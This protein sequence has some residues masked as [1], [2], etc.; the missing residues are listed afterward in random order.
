MRK[1]VLKS[2]IWV[3]VCF[4]SSNGWSQTTERDREGFSVIVNTD[5]EPLSSGPFSPHWE[6]LQQYQVPEWF[7]DAKFGIWA[8]WGPQCEP[9][10]GDW[11]ARLM[12]FQGLP[13]YD[14]HLKQYGH[15]SEVGFKEVIHA[16]EGE[17][18]NPDQL[19][20]LF[21]KAGAKYFFAMANHHDNLDLWDSRYHAW[22]S[23]KV[24]P[25]KNIV[26]GW[27]RAS[28]KYKLPF[29]LSVHSSHAWTWYEGTLGSDKTG[30]RGGVAYDGHLRKEDGKGTWWEGLDP[31]ELYA[32]DHPHSTD[33]DVYSGLFSQ[34][35][36]ENGASLPDQAYCDNF[37]NR[38]MDLIRRYRPDLVYFDDTV[39]PLY[40]FSDA[41]LKI[42][43][44]FYNENLSLNRGKQ[45]GVVFG[46]MLSEAQRKAMVWDIERGVSHEILP[47]P[48][49]TCTCIGQW[50]YDRSVYE[51][52]EYKSALTVLQMLSDIV[53]K[54]GNLLLSVPIRGDGSLDE[55]E[56]QILEDIAGWIK[57]NGEAIF[58][59]RPWKIFGESPSRELLGL[60]EQG[61][62]ENKENNYSHRDIRFTTRGDI[63][64]A[65]ILQCD[66][67]HSVEIASLGKNSSLISGRKIQKI[68]Q[69]GSTG[70]PDWNQENNKLTVRIDGEGVVVLRIEGLL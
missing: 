60:K 16:W 19:V 43:S 46:K 48:W 32:N 59:T 11:Y 24:G 55:K 68:K 51:K 62:D 58:E 65:I 61:F 30:P 1:V 35:R 15:P 29:G 20:A 7:R 6:S 66:G 33:W 28:R 63:L 3:C 17:R 34:W 64:Y 47:F 27:A 14:F 4:I 69:L 21:K 56:I 44:N 5:V 36:W 41:G 18:W 49:Q 37:Y 38:T 50:H 54:N 67:K 42:V 40:P 10:A 26:D 25:K 2:W 9:E 70:Q 8:H 39:L 13:Q 52:D 57:V 22:N 31:R 53:S 23:L 12:Y 45:P